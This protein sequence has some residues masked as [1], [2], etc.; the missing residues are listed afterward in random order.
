MIELLVQ[1]RTKAFLF[2]VRSDND[3]QPKLPEASNWSLFRES[4][5]TLV[6]Y[7]LTPLDA[8]RG[9]ECVSQSN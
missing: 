1:S 6:L 2:V 3:P 9:L 7:E 4:R 5:G 8:P